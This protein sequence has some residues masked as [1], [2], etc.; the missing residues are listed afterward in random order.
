MGYERLGKQTGVRSLSFPA[1]YACQN[2]GICCSSA[3]EV[4]VKER[5]ELALRPRLSGASLR[6]PHGPNGFRP[7]IDPPNGCT[8]RLRRHEPSGSCWFHDGV[9]RL[10]A[11]HREFGESA[12][13]SACRQFPRI[14][15]LEP[16]VVSVSLSHYCPTAAAMLFRLSADFDVV[17]EAP[18]FPGSWPYEGLDA[19]EAYPP[20]L[21]HGVIL[22]F[23]GL[24]AFEASA[25]EALRGND[26]YLGLAESGPRLR[27]SEDGLPRRAVW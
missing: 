6:L 17:A 27:A 25:V 16:G 1:D 2:S 19:R 18:A 3:W 12:L 20:F 4:A 24:R 26:V 22:G 21:R 23:D 8:S 14:C 5:V 11:V 15:V 13:P 9:A 10:C 7:M